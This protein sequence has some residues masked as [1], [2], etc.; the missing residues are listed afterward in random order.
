MR[1]LDFYF[2]D[3][4]TREPL[5]GNPLAVVDDADGLDAATMRRI[6]R[7]FNQSETTFVMKAARR[8]AT[9][10]CHFQPTRAGPSLPSRRRLAT[11][12]CRSTSSSTRAA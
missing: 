2:V 11:A 1:Q 6:A 5:A 10:G 4:F 12:C 8:D 3:V 7:E 9:G